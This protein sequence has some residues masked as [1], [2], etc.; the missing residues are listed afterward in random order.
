MHTNEVFMHLGADTA[1]HTSTTH[2][3][4]VLRR[5]KQY[6]QEQL[7]AVQVQLQSLHAR[8]GVALDTEV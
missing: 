3:T 7:D 5:R 1:V 2:A 4:E 6:V 8:K